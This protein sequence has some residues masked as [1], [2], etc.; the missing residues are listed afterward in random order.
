MLSTSIEESSLTTGA[1]QP[2]PGGPVPHISVCVC[3]FKRPAL[4]ANL[5]KGLL[6]QRTDGKFGFS[7][8][9]VD[10]DCLGSARK[11]VES[12]RGS[13]MAI[14][15]FIEP[16]QSI[17]LARNR[18]VS[19]AK[20]DFVA[21]IDDDEYPITDWLLQLYN[22]L[23]E[24]KADGVLG[25]V[26]AKFTEP[27]SDWMLK[28]GVFDRPNGP[29]YETGSVLDWRR[30]GTGNVLLRR[31]VFD[32]VEGPFLPQFGSGG[33]D[34]DFFRR[35]SSM[36]KVFIWCNEALAHETVPPERTRVWFQ[37]RRALLRGKVSVQQPSGRGLGLM[38]SAAAFCIYTLL[39]PVFLLMGRPMFVKYLVKDFDHI[40]KLLAVCRINVVRQKYVVK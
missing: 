30:T 4:L 36:G 21:F 17:A 27:P 33:E 26:D 38:K 24:R 9:I 31:A 37:L 2:A 39:L 15:Y 28:T 18:A 6:E 19:N 7:V 23:V 29:G 20:G 12:F 34:L 35:A 22:T 11:T 40:G 10:N 25:P 14:E 5:L 16:E 13:D 3:T 32:V 1:E 8:V